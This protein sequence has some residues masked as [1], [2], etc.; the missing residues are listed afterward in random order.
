MHQLHALARLKPGFYII[1]PIVSVVSNNA[2]TIETTHGNVTWTI[3]KD[4]DH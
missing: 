1:V 4:P 3:A 2:Q